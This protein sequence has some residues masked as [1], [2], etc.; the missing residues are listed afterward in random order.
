MWKS[1]RYCLLAPTGVAAV[2]I[3]GTTIHSALGISVDCKGLQVSKLPDKKRCSLRI[4]LENL[5]AIIIDEN[6]F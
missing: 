2:N 1:Q 3:S 6:G 4:E 5:K